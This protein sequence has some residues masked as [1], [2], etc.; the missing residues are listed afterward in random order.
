MKTQDVIIVT[1]FGIYTNQENLGV[2][3]NMEGVN[4]DIKKFLSEPKTKWYKCTCGRL[5]DNE[6]GSVEL[7]LCG[8]CMRIKR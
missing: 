6:L 1:Q 8:Y 7:G 4:K 3:E 2:N 5:F